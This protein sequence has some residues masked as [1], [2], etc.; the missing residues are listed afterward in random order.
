MKIVTLA[1]AAEKLGWDFTY[2]TRLF[3]AGPIDGGILHGDLIVVGSG[4]PSIDDW[5]GMAAAAV[6][7]LGRPVEERGDQP[8]STAA[9]SA[10]TTRSTTT[11][12]GRAG[13]GTTS[14]TSFSASVSA[15]QFNEGSVQLRLAPGTSVGTRAGVTVS[16]DYSGLTLNNLITTGAAGSTTVVARRRFPGSSRLELR[17]VLP[18][19]TPAVLGDGVGGQP[20][21][22]LRDRPPPFARRERHRRGRTGRGHRRSRSR[23]GDGPRIR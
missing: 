4:D 12:S 3:A 21:A 10:T 17:G 7:R 20:D 16:P 8:R 19:R 15:L 6:R 13:R 1:A 14:R 9:S 11:G 2:Q 5:D 23:A 22:V 18:L